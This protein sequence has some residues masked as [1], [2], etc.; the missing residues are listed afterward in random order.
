MH[1]PCSPWRPLRLTR[2][3]RRISAGIAAKDVRLLSKVRRSIETITKMNPFIT[4]VLITVPPITVRDIIGHFPITLD[5]I[6]TDGD[7]DHGGTA[8]AA[9][10]ADG[11]AGTGTG[12]AV[13]AAGGDGRSRIRLNESATG[14]IPCVH[15]V[16]RGRHGECQRMRTLIPSS[17]LPGLHFP[18]PAKKATGRA[19]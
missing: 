2:R 9:A 18:A 13:I 5:T 1:F 14:E 8:I 3:K 12:S 6:P 4:A 19:A 16:P 11:A 7:L 10:G 15:S 17:S